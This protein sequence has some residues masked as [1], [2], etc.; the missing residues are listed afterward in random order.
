MILTATQL[1]Q[2][3]YLM[4]NVKKEDI[5]ITKRDRPFAVIVD[6][7]RYDALIRNQKDKSAKEEKE[8]KKIIFEQAFGMLS[9]QSIDPVEWQNSIR[10]ESD[11][12]L[13]EQEKS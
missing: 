10:E 1:K 9:S 2:Q 3:T 6:I 7:E 12:R 13:Y 4:D 8:D 5:V 11:S